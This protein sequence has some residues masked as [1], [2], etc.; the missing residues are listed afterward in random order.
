MKEWSFII[1]TDGH[2]G[3]F[4]RELTAYC[5]GIT[6]ECEVGRNFAREY[7]GADFESVL[8]QVSDDRGFHRPCSTHCTPDV[9]NDGL[10]G[11]YREGEEK[12]ATEI[13]KKS[14]MEHGVEFDQLSKYPAML[15]VEI[16]FQEEPK[17]SQ[18]ETIREKCYEFCQRQN[19]NVVGFRLKYKETIQTIFDYKVL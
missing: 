13:Y 7:D 14:C 4:H 17:D 3:S 11:I 6:G 12:S 5:T 15:S 2:A 19:I 16:F 8:R 1:D 18:L 9:Y 10:G